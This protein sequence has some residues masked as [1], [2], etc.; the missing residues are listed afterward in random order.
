LSRRVK[1][2]RNRDRLY[3]SFVLATLIAGVCLAPVSSGSL[4]DAEAT[5]SRD[6][7]PTYGYWEIR[8]LNDD[9]SWQDGDSDGS[10]GGGRY[11]DM[12]QAYL[13]NVNKDYV[14]NEW[15]SSVSGD[16]EVRIH[17]RGIGG[18]G[19]L[20]LKYRLGGSGSWVT[21]AEIGECNSYSWTTPL[22][23]FDNIFYGSNLELWFRLYSGKVNIAPNDAWGGERIIQMKKLDPPDTKYGYMFDSVFR[24]VDGCGENMPYCDDV[25]YVDNHAV[26]LHDHDY[27]KT[28]T[29][30]LP[31]E[32]YTGFTFWAKCMT[33]KCRVKLRV[34]GQTVSTTD[35]TNSYFAW[36]NLGGKTL[37]EGEHVVR[38]YTVE[39]WTGFP[40]VWI[41][42][43]I[44]WSKI[45]VSQSA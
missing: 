34:D 44:A 36:V 26:M 23:E 8:E 38:L 12:D 6:I 43:D 15:G 24:N 30:D 22:W 45:Y 37:T 4:V 19:K 28:Y 3:V 13:W 20:Q 25:V 5:A 18:L 33:S 27:V 29:G 31:D 16:Y 40:P 39:E 7:E 17:C 21:H 32:R 2:Y 35:F 14:Q 11:M 10:S 42:S 1:L 41:D 9:V